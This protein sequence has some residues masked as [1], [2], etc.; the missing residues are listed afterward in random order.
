MSHLDKLNFAEK[1][2]AGEKVGR[3]GKSALEKAKEKFV[4]EIGLQLSLAKDPSFKEKIFGKRGRLKGNLI[5]SRKLRSWVTVSGTDAYITPRF[6][7]KP[8][9]LAAARGTGKDMDNQPVL[10]LE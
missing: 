1:L 2:P 4:H 10:Y 6:S 5:N 8:I 3:Q 7:N 9:N